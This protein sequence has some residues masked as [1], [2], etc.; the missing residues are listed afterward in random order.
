L[1]NRKPTAS[2]QVEDTGPKAPAQEAA[3]EAFAADETVAPS[4]KIETQF[5]IVDNTQAEEKA[6]PEAESSERQ[7]DNGMTVVDY[8]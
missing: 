3:L 5:E 2:K 1:S 8:V 4:F 6:E 7:L